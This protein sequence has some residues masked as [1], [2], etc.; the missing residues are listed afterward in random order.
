MVIIFISSSIPADDFPQ[1]DFWGWAKL[2]HLIYYGFLCFLVHR[3]ILNQTRYP[4]LARHSYLFGIF[5]AVLYGASDEYHQ[6]STPGRHGQFT[7][8][9]ID[10][11]GAILFIGVVW[12]Y[13]TLRLRVTSGD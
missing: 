8:V 12:A 9:L 1:V 2:I 10:A 11:V 7:D 5:F 13:R 6:L 4:L 3:A